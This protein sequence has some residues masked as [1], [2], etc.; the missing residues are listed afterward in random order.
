MSKKTVLILWSLVIVLTISVL[1]LKWRQGDSGE[2]Q[3]ERRRGQTLLESFAVTDVAKITLKGAK[4]TTTLQ[5]GAQGW[6]VVERGGYAANFNQINNL[7]RTLETVKVNQAIEA[8]PT[9]GARFGMDP[10]ARAESERGVEMVFR[11]ADD[12][13]ITTILLGKDSSGGGRFVRRAE[14]TTGI[15]VTSESFPAATPE[16]KSWLQDDFIDIQKIQSIAVSAPGNPKKIDWRVARNTETAEFGLDGAKKEDQ[17]DSAANSSLKSLLSSARFEDVSMKD[18]KEILTA[19]ESRD[20]TI[21]TIDGF[22]Y[23]LTL[24]PKP[25]TEVPQALAQPSE[26]SPATEDNCFMVLQVD[27]KFPA[28]RTKSKDETPEAAKAADEQFQKN[29]RSLKEKLQ[30]EQGFQGKV[31][32]VSKYSVEN[33]LKSR[34]DLLQTSSN[35][36]TT[37]PV[38]P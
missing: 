16:P 36:A 11:K 15:Y 30:K 29:Q 2:P 31:F 10:Q 35:E 27:A 22:T 5:R 24:L 33:L 9:Y 8:G 20:A 12:S 28:E 14:D 25:A 17:L 21:T 26:T 4:E 18:T 34:K 38:S 13:V 3:T 32:V 6:Q 19:K 1:S 7:L 23:K 37:P